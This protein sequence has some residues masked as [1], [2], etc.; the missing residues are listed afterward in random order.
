MRAHAQTAENFQRNSFACGNLSL[1]T[2]YFPLLQRQLS[3]PSSCLAGPKWP[4][5]LVSLI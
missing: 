4:S 1:L 5:S 2:P 3:A